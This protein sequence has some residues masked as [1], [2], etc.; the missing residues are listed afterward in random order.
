MEKDEY[1]IIL[2]FLPYGYPIG[3]KPIPIAQAVGENTWILLELI[4]RR[5]VALQQKE[6]VY[7]GPD[8]RDKIHYIGGRLSFEK[9]T[10]SAKIQLHE[11]IE[12]EVV[13][14]EKKLI[15]F[16]NAAQAINTRLHQIEL[17]PGFGR[18]HTQELLQA[19][20]E[21]PFESFEEM[22]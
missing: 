19:R 3:G 13:E 4:T 5:G 8:K 6:K 21:K 18:K 7:I 16:F 9:I 22:R 20:E 15:D 17:L 10:E 14:Q 2:D 12:E 11:F 1:A